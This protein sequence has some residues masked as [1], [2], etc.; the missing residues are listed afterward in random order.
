MA[1]KSTYLLFIYTIESPMG[2]AE[3][4]VS[5]ETL[6]QHQPHILNV[7]LSKNIGKETKLDKITREFLSIKIKN[8]S[9][10]LNEFIFYI[11]YLLDLHFSFIFISNAIYIYRRK[12]NISTRRNS[13]FLRGRICRLYSLWCESQNVRFIREISCRFNI[14]EPL[15]LYVCILN[16]GALQ[17]VYKQHQE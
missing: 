17:K 12:R 1:H 10:I 2:Y 9:P 3:T 6:T 11:D 8:V 15:F 7:Q 5:Y 4:E 13:N 16:G 14:T